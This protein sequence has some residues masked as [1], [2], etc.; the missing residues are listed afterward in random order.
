MQT[1][2]GGTR[3]KARRRIAN[4][5]TMESA[6]QSSV[7]P[8]ACGGVD[9]E[10]RSI[11]WLEVVVYVYLNLYRCCNTQI[12]ESHAES[13]HGPLQLLSVGSSANGHV[14][15]LGNDGAE[16]GFFRDE[17]LSSR[18]FEVLFSIVVPSCRA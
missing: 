2:E 16:P 4:T 3:K 11:E 12:C 9:V 13:L 15:V 18:K 6:L 14:N 1:S 5:R 10:V 8:R 17:A 7:W